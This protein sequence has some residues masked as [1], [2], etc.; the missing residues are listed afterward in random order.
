MFFSFFRIFRARVPFYKAQKSSKFGKPFC[1]EN[2]ESKWVRSRVFPS[3]RSFARKYAQNEHF[4]QETAIQRLNYNTTTFTTHD[5]AVGVA[6]C[7]I[8]VS[9]LRHIGGQFA[10][11]WFAVCGILHAQRPSPTTLQNIFDDIGDY[12]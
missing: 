7:G 9:N 1:Q 8:L 2:S 3:N 5:V 4:S 11:Y 12:L 6:I 10:A